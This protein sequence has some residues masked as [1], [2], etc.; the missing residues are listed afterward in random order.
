MAPL[1]KVSQRQR[2]NATPTM[3]IIHLFHVAQHRAAVAHLIHHEFWANVPGASVEGMASRLAF[4]H[5]ADAVP[6]CLV[7][8][9]DAE[10]PVGAVNLVES[11]DD[12]HTDWT[13]WLAGMVVA[14]PLRGQGIGTAL[15]QALLLEAKRL[16]VPQVYLGSDGPGFYTRLGAVV[17]EQ[18]R[19]EFWFL[20]FDLSPG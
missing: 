10:Q 1:T 3:R 15:V 19:A 18:P 5:S 20:R 17:V 9:N 4:A 13:P 7:A 16:G 14:A 8:L 6:L 11:D 2:E 12:G